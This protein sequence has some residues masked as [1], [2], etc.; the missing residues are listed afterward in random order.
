MTPPTVPPSRAFR[1][2]SRSRG[3]IAGTPDPDY[4]NEEGVEIMESL[5]SEPFETRHQVVKELLG[6]VR[7]KALTQNS[8]TNDKELFGAWSEA[9]I[10]LIEP[11]SDKAVVLMEDAPFEKVIQELV[12]LYHRIEA[13]HSMLETDS[14]G[15]RRVKH[16][17]RIKE[18][19]RRL[20]I[21][22]NDPDGIFKILDFFGSNPH[23]LALGKRREAVQSSLKIIEERAMFFSPIADKKEDRALFT[24][25]AQELS[26]LLETSEEPKYGSPLRVVL[27]R[28]QRDELVKLFHAITAAT[29]MF[30]TDST[31]TGRLYGRKPLQCIAKFFTISE[32]AKRLELP[33]PG[34]KPGYIREG[35]Q[36]SLSKDNDRFRVSGLSAQLTV[37]D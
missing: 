31:W 17:Y 35:S 23:E 15:D 10:E 3:S 37:E 8:T 6:Q 30:I 24:V 4:F 5:K 14:Q 2:H 16:Y 25:W 9:F 32:I 12:E 22:Y 29:P 28:H 18:I 19:A 27:G 7:E 26:G 11:P 34:V 1:D 20:N 21:P 36:A 13:D 33:P